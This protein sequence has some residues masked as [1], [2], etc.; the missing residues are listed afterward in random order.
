MEKVERD[1][2]P[3]CEEQKLLMK[4]LRK[5]LSKK[6]IVIDSEVIEETVALMERRFYKQYDFQRFM[7]ALIVGV[8]HK[9]NDMLLFN[10]IFIEGGRGFGKNGYVSALTT[11]LI[12]EVNGIKNYNVDIVATAEDQAKTSFEDIY[13]MIDDNEEI[14]PA[15]NYT[16]IKITHK[17]TNSTV[18]YRTS[19]AKTK[20]GLR[21]GCVIFDEVHEYTDYKNINVY[22]SALGKTKDPRRIYITT[23]GYVRDAVLDDLKNKSKQI[24]NG[25]MPHNGF[26]PIIFKMDN[27]DQ[28]ENKKLWPMANPR[29]PYAPEL[30]HEMEI[31]FNDM[32][33]NDSVKEEFITKRMNLVYVSAD[34]VV[35]VWDDIKAACKDP[36]PD[37][38]GCECL[39]V[40]DYADINDFASVGLYFKYGNKRL[41]KQH[42]FIHEKALKLKH[43]N[44]DI[45]EAVKKGWATIVRDTPTIPGELIASWFVRQSQVYNIKKV[46][47]DR[48][49][50]SGISQDFA[51][52]G[53]PFEGR[54]FGP[55]THM[56]IHPF[57]NKLF[58][59]RLIQLEDD[60]LM[61]WYINNV[62]VRTNE[63]G[64]KE[65]Y[66]IE[67]KRR[68]TDGMFAFLHG[69]A[70][71]D[72]LA[73]ATT[74]HE[75]YEP[76]IF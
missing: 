34:K 12:S 39:G 11:A 13:A 16:K 40:L 4:F 8:R 5:E 65:F 35:A 29:L 45:D 47:G 69:V 61:R 68:K 76:M 30:M 38:I 63:V 23:D 15:F 43:Y 24:L 49:R 66:K 55:K 75:I 44:I 19:N 32:Y 67:P 20:D 52:A 53:I 64:N 46:V 22:T 21:P 10:Q 59:E 28:I 25:E 60:K 57:V 73:D 6:S 7:T 9:R 31:Q 26:L 2:V 48:Y 37:I 54:F 51:N 14:Q 41:F 70:A 17:G 18:R 62:G 1:K 33:T 50:I 56:M 3:A 71:D 27:L 74:V 72:D 58:T 42:S 36:W